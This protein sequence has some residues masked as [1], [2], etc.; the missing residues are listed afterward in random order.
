[1]RAV[2]GLIIAAICSKVRLRRPKRRAGR[3]RSK[4]PRVIHWSLEYLGCEVGDW[5]LRYEVRLVIL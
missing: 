2:V 1:M 3:M 5:D 4:L